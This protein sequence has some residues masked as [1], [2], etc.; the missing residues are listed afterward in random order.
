MKKAIIITASDAY[1]NGVKPRELR[2]YLQLHGFEVELMPTAW[3]TRM[4]SKGILKKIHY[5]KPLHIFIY[6]T[7][8]AILSKCMP[9]HKIKIALKSAIKLPLLRSYATIT[10]RRLLDRKPDLIIC[11]TNYDIGF[12]LLPR[13]A[14]LQILDLPSP[15]AEELF[16]GNQLNSSN[17]KKMKEYENIAYKAADALSFHWHTYSD[18]VKLTKYQGNNIIDMGY[19]TN[20][21]NITAKYSKQPKIIFLGFLAGYW[22]NLPLLE[23]ISELCPQ[24]DV[25]GGPTPKK[26]SKINYKGYAPT[27]DVMAEYQFGLTTITDDPLRRNSFSSKHLE[28]ISYGLPVMTPSWRND[29]KL[30]S[31]SIYFDNAEDFVNKIKEYS[32]R[33]KWVKKHKAALE[34]AERMQWSNVFSDLHTLLQNKDLL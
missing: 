22:V 30:D 27:L 23:K 6:V 9:I 10:H 25:F 14:K 19:G 13:V 29:R 4:G 28:Y 33:N 17:Y 8:L 12:T 32:T 24:L 34:T 5:I 3:E 21:K 1:A 31:S 20:I 26:G 15:S 2:K 16:Y 18:Y 11:E 7:I